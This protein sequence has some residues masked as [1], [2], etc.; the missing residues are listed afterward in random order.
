MAVSAWD[1][2]TTARSGDV[3]EP[4]KR[5]SE[6]RRTHADRGGLGQAPDNVEEVPRWLTRGATVQSEVGREVEVRRETGRVR[7]TG[8]KLEQGPN[9]L[10]SRDAR[11][12]TG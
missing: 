11:A 2:T 6:R 1:R 7:A 5:E 3:F 8:L 10:R 12:Q 9:D 4:L